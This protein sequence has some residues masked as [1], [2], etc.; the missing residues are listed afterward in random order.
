MF[1]SWDGGGGDEGPQATNPSTSQELSTSKASQ[2]NVGVTQI[3]DDDAIAPDL[4]V[5]V[6]EDQGPMAILVAAAKAASDAVPLGVPQPARGT[7]VHAIF[8]RIIILAE[9]QGLIKGFR[10]E[11]S[12]IDHSRVNY[13]RL[14]SVR[15]DVVFGSPARPQLAVDLKT[16][17]ARMTNGQV[18]RYYDNLP[19]GSRLYQ[20]SVP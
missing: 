8:A 5:M 19:V 3:L 16:G 14:G 20:I 15:A 11:V 12:Y 4:P 9:R 10:A 17:R 7:A 6:K 2:S 1:G 13:G 18:R